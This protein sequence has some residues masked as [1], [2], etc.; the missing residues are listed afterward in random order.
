MPTIDPSDG[1]GAARQRAATGG[2][3]A[4]P[5]SPATRSFWDGEDAD[6]GKSEWSRKRVMDGVGCLRRK[7]DEAA[8][9]L[10]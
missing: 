6:E 7:R 8:D 10:L 2:M 9:G 1:D 3:K 5:S 4:C